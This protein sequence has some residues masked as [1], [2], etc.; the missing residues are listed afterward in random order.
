MIKRGSTL[1]C[2]MTLSSGESECYALLRSSAHAVGIKAMLND[3]HY[4]MNCEMHMRCESSAKRGMSAGQ[5]LGT[6]DVRFLW[7]QAV[8]EGRVKVLSVPTSENLSDTFTKSLSQA[9][10]D[11]CHRTEET[12][13]VDDTER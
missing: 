1:Q 2:T 7:Q 11:L 6:R 13:K 5:G 9:D 8:Q 12:L 10:A 3:W 4:G